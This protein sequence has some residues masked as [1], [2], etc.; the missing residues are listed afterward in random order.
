MLGSIRHYPEWTV[1]KRILTKT[2]HK[3]C[4]MIHQ[5]A[6]YNNYGFFFGGGGGGG[7][8]QLKGF[9]NFQRLL[10]AN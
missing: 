5:A 8:E 1:T 7:G 6:L 9:E 4:K 10:Q 2:Q 3:I